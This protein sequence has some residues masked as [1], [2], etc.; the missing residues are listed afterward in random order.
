MKYYQFILLFAAA[1]GAHLLFSHFSSHEGWKRVEGSERLT[2]ADDQP[3]I[4]YAS[5]N[6]TIR[7]FKWHCLSGEVRIEKIEVKT[8]RGDKR[9]Y[10]FTPGLL[11]AGL[12]TPPLDLSGVNGQ[13]ASIALWYDSVPVAHHEAEAQVELLGSAF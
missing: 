2:T 9:D 10:T 5:V 11:H 13:V 4:I 12:S 1:I 3:V 8:T 6:P 7:Q